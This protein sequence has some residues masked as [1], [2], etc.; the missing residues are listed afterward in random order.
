MKEKKNEVTL[1]INLFCSV[2]GFQQRGSLEGGLIPEV[3]GIVFGK[4]ECSLVFPRRVESP[5]FVY[6]SSDK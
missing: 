1:H 3:F 5:I 4:L 2:K 6:H